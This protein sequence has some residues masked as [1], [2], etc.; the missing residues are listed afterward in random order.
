MNTQDKKVSE[1]DANFKQN[2]WMIENDRIKEVKVEVLPPEKEYPVYKCANCKCNIDTEWC[3]AFPYF[4][5]HLCEDCEEQN[6]IESEE[7]F[8]DQKRDYERGLI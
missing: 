2:K 3:E 4:D 6:R 1:L 8:R 7:M 5:G